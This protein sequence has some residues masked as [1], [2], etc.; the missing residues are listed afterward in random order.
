MN[1]ITG[2]VSD[3]L[4]AA[5]GNPMLIP[6]SL[7]AWNGA[8]DGTNTSNNQYLSIKVKVTKNGETKPYYNGWAAVGINGTWEAG[9]KYIYT[10]D[11]TNGVGKVDPE[12]LG[13]PDQQKPNQPG[14]DIMGG[15][16]KFNVTV[17]PWVTN[18]Q[19]ITM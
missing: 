16:I 19:N 18:D 5:E 8:A 11:L 6:Q 13:N 14:E 2:A 7:T 12:G 17:E 3:L 15:E 9:N 10:L 4:V 1:T